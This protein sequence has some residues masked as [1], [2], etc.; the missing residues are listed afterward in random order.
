MRS[1]RERSPGTAAVTQVQ[2]DAAAVLTS[3]GLTSSQ[4]SQIQADQ[5]A[6]AHGD[7]GRPECSRTVTSGSSATQSTLQSVSAYLIGIA[8]ASRASAW[9][10]VRTVLSGSELWGAAEWGSGP[11]GG[12]FTMGRWRRPDKTRSGDHHVPRAEL[13][14]INTFYELDSNGFRRQRGDLVHHDD[15]Q[16]CGEEPQSSAIEPQLSVLL[17]EDDVE[18]CELMREFLAARESASRR[19]TTA[20]A[21]WHKPSDAPMI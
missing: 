5:Q 4:V 8:R 6:L 21:G 12:P 9:A 16:P 3:M 7:R 20:A 14:R 17:I 19:S 10:A 1:A 2:T 13:T 15:H 18:L 11:R